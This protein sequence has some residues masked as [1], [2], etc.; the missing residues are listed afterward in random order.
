M[1]KFCNTF[2]I[3]YFDLCTVA[4]NVT[5]NKYLMN[6]LNASSTNA[7]LRW[8]EQKGLLK[9]KI[10]SKRKSNFILNNDL[11]H[12]FSNDF[13]GNLDKSVGKFQIL[14]KQLFR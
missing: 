9:A 2:I 14:M 4:V 6:N 7:I 3:R 12:S 11:H 13:Y 1:T 5:L 8:N 10:E